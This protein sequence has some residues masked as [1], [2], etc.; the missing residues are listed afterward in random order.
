MD[1]QYQ[2][3]VSYKNQDS[4]NREKRRLFEIIF[5]ERLREMHKIY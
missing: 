4:Y 5:A 2:D 1:K 3:L